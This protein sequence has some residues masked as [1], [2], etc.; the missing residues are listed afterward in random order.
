MGKK[1]I[2][3]KIEI[4]LPALVEVIEKLQRPS[5]VLFNKFREQEQE[6]KRLKAETGSGSIDLTDVETKEAFVG[7]NAKMKAASQKYINKGVIWNDSK[8]WSEL[9]DLLIAELE[10]AAAGKNSIPNVVEL[11]IEHLRSRGIGTPEELK[12]E[13]E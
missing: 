13:G 4:P 11:L 8:T 12:M 3:V 1:N 6:E 5:L 9:F 10:I 2:K 7:F